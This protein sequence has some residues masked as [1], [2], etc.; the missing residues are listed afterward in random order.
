MSVRQLCCGSAARRFSWTYRETEAPTM[1]T[2]PRTLQVAAMIIMISRSRREPRDNSKYKKVPIT[3]SQRM[4]TYDS[5][6]RHYRSRH[7]RRSI[8]NRKCSSHLRIHK[9]IHKTMYAYHNCS[10][11]HPSR[12]RN[13]FGRRKRANNRCSARRR[14]ESPTPNGKAAS[15]ATASSDSLV[16]PSCPRSHIPD[17][18]PNVLEC[19]WR[20]FCTGKIRMRNSSS[21][22]R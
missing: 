3:L 16:R 7:V 5:S 6:L 17:R 12:H 14:T 19:I 11:V 13:R 9:T 4:H 22:W 1:T 10:C 20:R 18:K 2:I 21:L 15:S 8:D